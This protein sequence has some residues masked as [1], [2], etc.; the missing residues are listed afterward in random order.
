MLDFFFNRRSTRKFL[1][2]KVPDEL[3]RDLLKAAMAAPS[4]GSWQPWEFVVV[5]DEPLKTALA[6]TSP[7]AKFVKDAPVIIAVAGR[8]D[9]PWA[10]FDCALAAGNILLAAANL[11][12]GGTYCGYDKER[13]AKAR[14]VLGIPDG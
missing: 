5:K 7:F 3:I 14:E 12:L 11:E 6:S 4:A 1:D 13:E 8:K 9:N 2:R 10:P